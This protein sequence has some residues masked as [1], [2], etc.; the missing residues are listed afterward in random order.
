MRAGVGPGGRG[1]MKFG[2]LLKSK[3]DEMEGAGEH[4]L[5]YKEL[6]KALRGMKESIPG[7]PPAAQ[8]GC[9]SLHGGM[10]HMGRGTRPR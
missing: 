8:R 7:A 6:K 10:A 1:G 2:K 3:A 4:F 5:R 9:G